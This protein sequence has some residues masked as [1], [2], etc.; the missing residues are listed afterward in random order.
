[1]HET[2]L[3]ILVSLI[4][5]LLA[6]A[7]VL[8]GFV[9]AGEHY[10]L[11]SFIPEGF[12]PTR[13][14]LFY[15]AL[16]AFGLAVVLAI[17][18]TT[19]RILR[20]ARARLAQELLYD[21]GPCSTSDLPIIS[22][23]AAEVFGNQSTS[24]A[25]TTVLHQLDNEVFQIIRDEKGRPKGYFCIIRLTAAG[26]AALQASSFSILHCP[27]EYIFAGKKRRY[28]NVYVGAVYGMN[29]P[30]KQT[31][32]GGMIGTIRGIKARLIFAHATTDSGLRI[33]TKY[34]F[35]TVNGNPPAIGE[36]FVRKGIL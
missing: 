26:V 8:L 35:K 20:A 2:F 12:R 34:G 24:I 17:V 9:G 21:F 30:A 3:R 33:L 7:G 5:G 27:V 18:Y 14:L 25:R 23:M 19:I 10:D 15:I 6:I 29:R 11:I 22:A 16:A 1:M 13:A 4:A 32:L 36:Y 31:A 28:T